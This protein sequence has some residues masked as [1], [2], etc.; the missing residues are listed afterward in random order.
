M[1]RKT[2]FE[3]LATAGVRGLQPYVPGKP[4]DELERQYGL[5]ES[6]KLAS[7]ENPLGPPSTALGAVRE[8]L[9]N[10]A[11]Y[12]DGSGYHLKNALAERHHV[13]SACIT[14]GN[15]SNEVLVLLAETFLGPDVEAVFDQYGFIVGSIACGLGQLN[16][17][18]R[19]RRAPSARAPARA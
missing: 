11:Q 13:D 2:G 19:S 8:S 18:L 4:V 1:Q 6:I 16:G 17:F 3:Q 15:G 12:P 5:R 10:L 7:N 9:A 14:L